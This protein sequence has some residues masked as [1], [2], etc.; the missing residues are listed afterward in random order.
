MK[1]TL[2][3]FFL[4]IALI[5]QSCAFDR[6]EEPKYDIYRVEVGT[7]LNIRATPSK[8]GTVLGTINNG[9]LVDVIEISDG[10]AK[11][12]Y[13][14]E[15]IGY[16]SSDYL[17][18]V[19]QAKKNEP[20]ETAADD[21]EDESGIDDDTYPI[22]ESD[23]T[24][25]NVFFIGDSTLLASYEK[26]EI[27]ARLKTSGEYTYIVNTVQSVP[28]GQLFDYAPGLLKDLSKE[29][30]SSMS[31]W[32]RFKSWF[33]GA[34]PSDNIVLISW[35]KGANLLQA[36]CNGNSLKYLKMS[37]PEEY[38]RLQANIRKNVPEAIV[39]L[40]LAIDKAGIEYSGR[41]WFV[42]SQINTGNIFDN[43]CESWIVENIL[44]RD[45]F[46]HKWVLGW[47][48]AIP[49]KFANWIMTIVHS[50]VTT[51][52]VLMIVMLGLYFF[53]IHGAVK[54]QRLGYEKT[55]CLSMSMASMSIIANIFL[56]LSM[57]SLLIYMMP[58]MSVVSVMGQS[59]YPQ[60]V[61]SVAISEFY[62]AAITKDWLL[63]LLFLLSTAIVMGINT[64]H[65]ISATL[66]SKTQKFLLD[67]QKD[68]LINEFQAKG[69]TFD[70]ESWAK[71]EFPYRELVISEFFGNLV[72][73]L[74]TVLPLSFVFNGSL[75]LYASIFLWT[76]SLKKA[77]KIGININGL[78]KQGA[79]K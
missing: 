1:Q 39:D 71:M 16:V 47:I 19:R 12:S 64:D 24:R 46:W 15:E 73:I 32:Q 75:L 20:T 35:I 54:Y 18:L 77:I 61:V 53:G 67:K 10:W 40:G 49:L 25:M 56:W 29:L 13:R 22:T 63:I 50:Y 31:W 28:T 78:R 43:I 74:L 52:V 4:L 2:H 59:G 65:F 45:S 33:G 37:E 76:I 42:R 48:F 60:K 11:V 3:L 51:L 70:Y 7:Y 62:S 72:K 30:D 27:E 34:S 21:K 5:L 26:E 41:S 9:A 68:D 23:A 66:P 44:P 38:F 8:K 79:Y 69:S 14:G 36:E 6:V 58:D 17:V 55:G 57:L